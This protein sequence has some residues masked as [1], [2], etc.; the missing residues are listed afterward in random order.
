M[1]SL[2]GANRNWT[3]LLS[4]LWHHVSTFTNGTLDSD[5]GIPSKATKRL[6]HYVVFHLRLKVNLSKGSLNFSPMTLIGMRR[7]SSSNPTQ[8]LTT[9]IT[10]ASLRNLCEADHQRR[11]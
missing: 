7:N 3:E 5:K 8:N 2:G 11:V 10:P 6:L 1:V 4:F 9:R